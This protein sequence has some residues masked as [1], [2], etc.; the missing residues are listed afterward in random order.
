MKGGPP[1]LD[2]NQLIKFA[3]PALGGKSELTDY[4]SGLFRLFGSPIPYITSQTGVLVHIPRENSIIRSFANLHVLFF[5]TWSVVLRD[6]PENL[7]QFSL[8]VIVNRLS[9]TNSQMFSVLLSSAI[10]CCKDRVKGVKVRLMLRALNPALYA[11][12]KSN[13]GCCLASNSNYHSSRGSSKPSM[14]PAVLDFAEET[15]HRCLLAKF[16]KGAMG[17]RTAGDR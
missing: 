11:L 7:G 16:R 14:Q 1:C 9:K 4:F 17:N 15:P 10:I 3:L 5:G 13:G 6:I 12:H 2:I 8:Y